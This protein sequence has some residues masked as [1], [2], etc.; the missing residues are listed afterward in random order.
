MTFL[1]TFW[2]WCLQKYF[3]M[4]AYIIVDIKCPPVSRDML[5]SEIPD[6]SL[7]LFWLVRCYCCYFF[8]RWIVKLHFCDLNYDAESVQCD[9]AAWLVTVDCEYINLPYVERGQS[10]VNA[11]LMG[12][13]SFTVGSVLLLCWTLMRLGLV[14]N[15][16]FSL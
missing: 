4:I 16:A 8:L 3:S 13:S 6:E 7:Y 14:R 11:K 10:T 5:H 9:V 1:E 2:L 15:Q 12:S